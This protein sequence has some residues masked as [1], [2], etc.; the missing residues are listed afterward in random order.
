MDLLLLVVDLV[1][2]LGQRKMEDIPDLFLLSLVSDVNIL[3]SEF[4]RN[5]ASVCGLGR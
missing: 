5:G 4:K 1:L 3:Q 2:G